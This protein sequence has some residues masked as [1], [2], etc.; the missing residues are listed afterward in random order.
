VEIKFWLCLTG[1][2]IYNIIY[3]IGLDLRIKI[4]VLTFNVLRLITY[5]F[6]KYK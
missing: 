2:I 1:I 4:N 5:K 6:K 3:N